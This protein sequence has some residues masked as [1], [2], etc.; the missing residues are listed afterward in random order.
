[1][2]P[3]QGQFH[4]LNIPALYPV[5]STNSDIALVLDNRLS[6]HEIHIFHLLV[7]GI[8]KQAVPVF[9]QLHQSQTLI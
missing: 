4:P 3:F 2:K 8:T 1:M 7:F 5:R 6:H 9:I